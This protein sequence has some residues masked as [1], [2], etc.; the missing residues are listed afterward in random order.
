MN[1]SRETIFGILCD[2]CLAPSGDNAQPWRFS[3]KGNVIRVINVPEKDDSLFNY[4]QMTNHVALGACVENLR[5]SAEGWGLK[6]DARLFPDPNNRLVVAE[7]TLTP[8]A[9]VKN[10]LAS[11]ITRRATN[12]KPYHPKPIEPEKLEIL[13]A[14]AKNVSG[15]VVFVTDKERVKEIAHIVSAGEKL[16]MENRSIH[17]FLFKHV[18]WT[19]GEDSKRH[20]FFIDTFEFNP[21][22]KLAFRIFRNWDILRF[23]LPFGVSKLV[24]RDARKLHST[25]AVFGAIIF[26][27]GNEGDYLKVGILLERIW[28]TVT[29]LGLALQPTTTV[30]FIATR[31]IAG[32]PGDLS[33]SHQELLKSNYSRLQKEFRVSSEEKIAFVFRLGYADSPTGATTRFAPEV[34]FED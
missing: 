6:A 14:L 25:S 22:Q 13:S 26:S 12:R 23:F 15:R 10:D 21:V 16:A 18:T 32:D 4:R 28:L 17:D 11:Y 3:V 1:P 9:S 33:M 20:G 34:V 5:V 27:K 31:V 24:A 8:D 19:K 30:H 29:K 2:A 7:V